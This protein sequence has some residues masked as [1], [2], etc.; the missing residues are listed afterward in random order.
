MKGA[1]PACEL[2]WG[3]L[4]TGVKALDVAEDVAEVDERVRARLQVIER[5]HVQA[6]V[7]VGRVQPEARHR[8]T[9]HVQPVAGD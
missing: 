7:H 4:L 3:W 6:Q 1:S 9:H 2:G 5:A 8:G